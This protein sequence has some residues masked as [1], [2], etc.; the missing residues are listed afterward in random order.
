MEE[1]ET[2]ASQ[3]DPPEEPPN[4]RVDRLESEVEIAADGDEDLAWRLY[5]AASDPIKDEAFLRRTA[6]IETARA[7]YERVIARFSHSDVP[8]IRDCVDGAIVM[9]AACLVSLG[10]NEEAIQTCGKLV[11]SDRADWATANKSDDYWMGHIAG[12]LY[13]EAT[14]LVRQ[15]WSNEAR[16][17]YAQLAEYGQATDAE[18]EWGAWQDEEIWA[19]E[20]VWATGNLAKEGELDHATLLRRLGRVDEATAIYARRIEDAGGRGGHDAVAEIALDA[21]QSR[22]DEMAEAERLVRLIDGMPFGPEHHNRSR[23]AAALAFVR[24]FGATAVPEMQP[25][26]ARALLIGWRPGEV[27][28]RYHPTDDPALTPYVTQ[29]IEQRRGYVEDGHRVFLAP[30]DGFDD[31]RV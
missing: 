27:V 14:C 11:R 25:L 7:V 8:A 2:G 17:T 3:V 9:S 21:V 26:V 5:F 30:Q 15:G 20:N 24:W 18:G 28:D 6:D 29:A 19:A 13:L 31:H 4:Q 12:G 1:H 23:Q 16:C 22:A 10:R